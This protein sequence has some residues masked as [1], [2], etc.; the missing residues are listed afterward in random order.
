MF[1]VPVCT[2]LLF[3]FLPSPP[4]PTPPASLL[5]L[6]I[7]LYLLTALVFLIHDPFWH[8]T[9]LVV[10]IGSRRWT[11]LSVLFGNYS[12]ICVSGLVLVGT[13]DDTSFGGY[14]Y[15]IVY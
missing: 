11:T 10:G 1:L 14:Y 8:G 4:S 13:E 7:R 6:N 5:P 9:R 12:G 2:P 3:P 15:W